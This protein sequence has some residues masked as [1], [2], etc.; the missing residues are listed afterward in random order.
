VYCNKN[1]VEI[2][3]HLREAVRGNVQKSWLETAGFF[4]ST[5]HLHITGL[6]IEVEVVCFNP[7]PPHLEDRNR[8]SF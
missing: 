3:R 5:M 4:C 7:L 1:S 8:C 6:V 2:F